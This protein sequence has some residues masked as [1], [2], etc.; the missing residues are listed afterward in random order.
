MFSLGKEPEA[1]STAAG[2]LAMGCL[3]TGDHF[4]I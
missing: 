3:C 4:K 2:M 1:L